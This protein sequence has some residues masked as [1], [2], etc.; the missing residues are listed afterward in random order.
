MLPVS[1]GT[2]P[3]YMHI[4]FHLSPSAPQIKHCLSL[5]FNKVSGLWCYHKEV[6]NPSL[7]IVFTVSFVGLCL[8]FI[9]SYMPVALPQGICFISWYIKYKKYLLNNPCQDLIPHNIWSVGSLFLLRKENF[10]STCRSALRK[11]RTNI[12]DRLTLRLVDGH[13][14]SQ[15]NRE[16]T[17]WKRNVQVSIRWLY[18]N[19]WDKDGL[20][21]FIQDPAFQHM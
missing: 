9:L 13:C 15:I 4:S 6:F 2:I 3:S 18:W 14:K 8:I 7:S 16:F 10:Y 21:I 17:T 20:S 12:L 11:S 19:P 5:R 1:I